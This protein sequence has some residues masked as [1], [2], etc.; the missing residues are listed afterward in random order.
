M[1]HSLPLPISNNLT[2]PL[3]RIYPICNFTRMI[4]RHTMRRRHLWNR[5]SISVLFRRTLS[6]HLRA[7]LRSHTWLTLTWTSTLSWRLYLLHTRCDFVFCILLIGLDP[8]ILLTKLYQYGVS[9]RFP[10]F[11]TFSTSLL[12][13]R[14]RDMFSKL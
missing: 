7:H 10:S 5:N 6:A 11:V 13:S 1:T 4:P 14:G 12:S 8:C 9:R 2:L 3:S